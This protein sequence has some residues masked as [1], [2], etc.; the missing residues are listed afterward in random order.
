MSARVYPKI[1]SKT[2]V[3]KKSSLIS[4]GISKESSSDFFMKL[5]NY[6]ARDFFTDY[7]IAKKTGLIEISLR[8][9]DEAFLPF[10]RGV[11]TEN[12]I[13]NTD[14][15]AIRVRVQ[16]KMQGIFQ[17]LSLSLS[18]CDAHHASKEFLSVP[19]E[20]DTHRGIV[21]VLFLMEINSVVF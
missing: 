19:P 8:C 7:S 2:I 14:P 10:F 1:C 6:S 3:E 13:F 9:K 12:K 20:R 11:K 5:L 4:L 15:Q 16:K 21:M 17:V 18:C